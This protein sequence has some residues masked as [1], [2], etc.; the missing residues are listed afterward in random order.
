MLALLGIIIVFKVSN[1]ILLLLQ[2]SFENRKVSSPIYGILFAVDMS[3]IVMKQD[4]KLQSTN[5]Y[6]VT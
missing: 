6:W 5:P 4:M 3:I 2:K 1:F